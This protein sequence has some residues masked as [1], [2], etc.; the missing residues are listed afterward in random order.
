METSRKPYTRE[1]KIEVVNMIT[2]GGAS[3]A[4]VTNDM[5]IP[6]ETLYH[7]IRELSAKPEPAFPGNG[8]ITTDAEV[9][10]KLR[11]ENERLKLEC[12]IL[13]KGQQGSLKKDPG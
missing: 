10:K 1:Y 3:P 6:L 7:W 5:D 8:H 12:K 4:Q 2:C 13:R 9:I 11:R